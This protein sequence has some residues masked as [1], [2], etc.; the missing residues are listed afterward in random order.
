M[1]RDQLIRKILDFLAKYP[2]QSFKTKELSRRLS[3]K[4]EDDYIFFK[5][6][7][8][9]LEQETLIKKIKKGYFGHYETPQTV[10]GRLDI[11]KSGLGFVQVDGFSKDIFIAPRFLGTA[12]PGDL[13]EVS[14]F[15]QGGKKKETESRHEGEIIRVLERGRTTIVGVVESVRKTH[16][17]IPDD[18]R[19]PTNILIPKENLKDAK[20]GEKV[21]AEIEVWGRHNA[22][23][24]GRVI[25][26]LGKTGELGTELRAVV[27]EFQLPTSFTPDVHAEVTAIP[28]SIDEKEIARRVDLRDQL[29]FTIDPEDA[30]DFDDAVS[31]TLG[32][33]GNYHLGVHIADVS[34]YVRENSA[35]DKEALKR[36]TSVY[37]PNS[38]IPMLPEV[39]SNGICSLKP[40]ETRF[41][42]SVFMIVTPRGSVQSYE[43]K[44]SVIRSKHRLSY[45][46]AE[47]IINGKEEVHDELSA[48]LKTMHKLSS[49]LTKKRMREGSI[50]FETAE[51]KFRFDSHGIPTD[52]VKKAR[53]ESHRLVEEFML[54]ANQTVAKHIGLVKKEEQARPFLYRIHDTPDVDRIRELAIFVNQFG[55]KLDVSSGISSK[56]LQKLLHQVRGTELENVINEVAL[57]T[58]AKAI[59]SERN[60][61][62]Y[63][64]AFD[65][66]SHFTSPIRRYPDLVIHRILKEYEQGVSFERRQV[67]MDRLPKIASNSSNRERV[68]M[69]AEREATKVMR[70]EFL[71]RHLGEEFKGIISGVTRYGIFVELLDSLAQGM[72][73]VR[74]LDDDYYLYDEKKFALIGQ[75]HG[76][77]YR[78]G[79]LVSVKVLRVDPVE[80][81]IDFV[82]V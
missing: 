38:V 56:T 12:L 21:V 4:S 82:L 3:I 67:L 66:Y 49:L 35:L 48:T 65:Y 24:Q 61:G 72:I 51:V 42:Y 31:L 41:T 5:E 68:A 46:E 29:C 64:L 22:T 45:E 43:I 55:Y 27:R 50:D 26:V 71:K 34:H 30:K 11:S 77:R 2:R 16:F 63:G 47:K 75:N 76:N 8:K 70:I 79:D 1:N 10:K 33:D 53:L 23:P 58:M 32:A 80:R 73:H 14:L 37:L 54:L 39:L 20:E 57:R 69:E 44:E 36:G 7:L 59:Y 62:H 78:L 19:F 28:L 18:R 17:V 52:V 9:E 25:E 6:I 81:E 15:A 74:D 40:N 13:V 60:I